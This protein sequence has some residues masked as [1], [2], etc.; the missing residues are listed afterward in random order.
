M[1][2]PF[3]PN[4]PV[5]TV[6]SRLVPLSQVL[7]GFSYRLFSVPV[8]PIIRVGKMWRLIQKVAISVSR[9][10]ACR[11]YFLRGHDVETPA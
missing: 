5:L 7:D 8:G 2:S 3:M 9:C 11:I 4:T 10:R 6:P 1:L